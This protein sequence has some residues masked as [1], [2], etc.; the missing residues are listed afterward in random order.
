MRWWATP[1]HETLEQ[2]REWVEAMAAADPAVS[3]DFVIEYEGRVIGKAGFWRLPDIGYIVHP[4]LWGRGLAA[5]AVAAVL[6]H[7]FAT[8]DLPEV[9]A[10]FDPNNTASRR[11][12]ERLGFEESGFAQRTW[13]IGG[14][15]YD[16]VYYRLRNPDPR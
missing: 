12:L 1:P 13:F 4:D 8:R 7:V 2:T 14:A 6:R 10:D 3:D 15:W 11:L 9:T 5:E 16:S